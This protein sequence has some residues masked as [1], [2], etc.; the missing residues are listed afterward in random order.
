MGRPRFRRTDFSRDQ[1]GLAITEFALIMPVMT[2]LAFGAF[3]LIR[4]IDFVSKVELA[5]S[6]LAELV[7]RNDTGK[8]SQTDIA[9]M[10][11]AQ[12][13]IFP[14]AMKVARDQNVAVWSLLKWSLTGIQFKAPAGCTSNCTYSAYV[15]WTSGQGRPCATPMN[16]AANTAAPTARTLPSDT[17]GPGFL[18]VADVVFSYTPIMAQSVIGTVSI[19]KSFYISPR[20]VSSIAFDASAGIGTAWSCVV[21]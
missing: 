17:F 12:L 1:R 20:Y 9:T 14:E 19:A 6:T 16:S 4:Y 7:S 21:P 11:K 5:A 2:L 8:I 13:V 15:A 3:D 10:S 18:I